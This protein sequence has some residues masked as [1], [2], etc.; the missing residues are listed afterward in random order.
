MIQNI[1][2]GLFGIHV[3]IGMYTWAAVSWGYSLAMFWCVVIL[4]VSVPVG[5]YMFY[6]GV[7]DWIVFLFG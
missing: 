7:P 1:L 3:L 4:P 6:F 5:I 2:A